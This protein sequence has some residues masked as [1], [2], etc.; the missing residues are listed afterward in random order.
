MNVELMFPNTMPYQER[1]EQ[2]AGCGAKHYGFW[3][4]QG[5]D[6]D[7]MLDVHHKH[8]LTCVSI[9]GNPRTGWGTGLT[10]TGAER[11]FLDDFEEVCRVAD[12]F[13]A[14][15]LITFVGAVQGDIPRETQRE[16]IIAGLKKAGAIAAKYDVYLTLEPL[17]RVESPRMSML[18]AREAYDFA[19]G[20]D[21]PAHPGRFRHLPPANWARGTSSI[22]LR[23]ASPGAMSASS[24]SVTSPVG[25]NR[26][27][28]R[29]TTPTSSD[30]CARPATPA[31]SA[32]S[33]APARLRGM[34]GIRY[35]SWPGWPEW[36]A[37]RPRGSRRDDGGAGRPIDLAP[38]GRP[39]SDRLSM[40]V[41]RT[42]TVS[43]TIDA[44]AGPPS[45][46]PSVP[47]KPVVL[48]PYYSGVEKECEDGLRALVR[49]GITVRR[50]SFSCHR[51]LAKRDVDPGDAER[52]R[53]FPVHRF[54][55]RLRP[56]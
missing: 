53:P 28:A 29:R 49:A 32:W 30:S 19:A 26:A 2:V 12:R 24:R 17:N 40:E 23:K 15:N 3:S 10:R 27:P 14:Q 22:R 13:G 6:L 11:A 55:H 52:L 20:A 4:W 39:G 18:T 1:L 9:S 35:G 34:P 25:R 56:R 7:R 5:K 42:E 44:S 46:P 45:A 33:T 50:A 16:Q 8:G 48:V 21:H 36:G 54:R 31:P 47:G 43:V 51:P 41:E 37:R 38:P